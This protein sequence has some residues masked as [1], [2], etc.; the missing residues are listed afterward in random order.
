MPKKKQSRQSQSADTTIRQYIENQE[1]THEYIQEEFS[2]T[3]RVS[4]HDQ[5]E[6]LMGQRIKKKETVLSA[7]DLDATRDTGSSGEETVGGS[8]PT[9]DQNN[10]DEL[11]KA[12]GLTFEDSE[13][14]RGEK[15]YDRDTDRWELDPASSEDYDERS[16]QYR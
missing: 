9:P 6:H 8:N 16:K 7:G 2:E 10:V 3:E 4:G 11:G 12:T 15:V 14:L 5:G 13:Q 1:P